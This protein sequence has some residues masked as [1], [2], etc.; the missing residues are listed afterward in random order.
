MIFNVFHSFSKCNLHPFFLLQSLFNLLIALNMKTKIASKAHRQAKKDSRLDSFLMVNLYI[1]YI[2]LFV[3]ETNKSYALNLFGFS[4][5]FHVI[6]RCA[7]SKQSFP[8]CFTLTAH[9]FALPL[10]YKL[11]ILQ[12]LLL[13]SCSF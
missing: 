1:V 6:R 7:K 11:N 9:S 4:H 12:L 2:I 8:S 5:S 10:P 3:F 13:I